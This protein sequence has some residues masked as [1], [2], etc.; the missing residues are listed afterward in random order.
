MVQSQP[1]TP[2]AT[3]NT[4]ENIIINGT[5]KQ[6]N[7]HEI[8]LVRERIRQIFFTYYGKRERK[9]GRLCHKTLPNMAPQKYETNIFETNNKR[10]RKLKIPVNWN[11]K[12]VWWN[13]Q[14]Q[15]SP[16]TG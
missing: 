6:R 2:V 16:G 4:V 15:G 10:H 12:R 13:Y 11:W 5:E 14:C 9:L 3:Y 7:R 1:P 8:L